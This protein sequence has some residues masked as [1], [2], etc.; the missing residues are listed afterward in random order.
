MGYVGSFIKTMIAEKTRNTQSIPTYFMSIPL[1]C[2]TLRDV[3]Q[4]N[5]NEI[6]CVGAVY[7]GPE[8]SG[9]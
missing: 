9:G 8:P 3:L 6:A 7:R 2:K 5:V 1:V 4:R